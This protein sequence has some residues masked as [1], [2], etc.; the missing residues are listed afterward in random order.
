MRI[1]FA[2]LSLCLSHLVYADVSSIEITS[3]ETLSAS[4]QAFSYQKVEG[5]IHLTLDP[6][7]SGNAAIVDIEF[8]PTNFEGLVEYAVDFKM[9]IPSNNIA[10]G[11][12]LYGVN[13]RGRLQTPPENELSA[14]D[15]SAVISELT[16]GGYTYLIT[17]WI[18]ELQS[19]AGRIRLHAPTVSAEQPITGDVRYELSVGGEAYE[20]EIA[21]AGHLA[22]Q[23][24]EAGMRNASLT[25]RLYQT[26][27][28]VPIERSRYDLIVQQ[29]SGANQP[30]VIIR[31]EDGFEPG[32]LYELIYEAQDPVLAG[33]GM[34][35]IRDIVSAIRYDEGEQLAELDLPEIDHTIAYGFSQS[36]RLLRQFVYDGFNA[37]LDQRKVFDGVVPYIAGGGYGMF[38][39]RFAMPTRTNGHHSNYLYPNDLFPFTYGESTDPYTGRTDSLLAKARATNTVPKVMH[40]QTTNEYWLR[41]GSLPHTT[42]EGREDSVIPEEVRFYTIGGS[43]H[44]SGSGMIPGEPTGGQLPRNPNMWQPIGLSLIIAMHDWI[45]ND[46][47]PPESVYPKIADGTLVAS[48]GRGGINNKAWNPLRGYNYPGSMYQPAHANY[49][50]RWESDRIVDAHP[51]YSDHFYRALVPAVDGNN[52]DLANSTILPPLTDVPLATFVSWNMRNPT[53]GAENSLA[54]LAGGYIPLPKDATRAAENGDQRD[55]IAGLYP[56]FSD[57]LAKYEASVD[58]LVERRFLLPEMKAIY[59]EIAHTRA[60]IFE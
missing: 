9:L 39:L 1:V 26:D 20:I 25:R 5:L 15:G 49:G 53:T 3:R 13:N 10:N 29:D 14:P 36:G 22:Y 42:P 56:S 28:R 54:R 38:N 4:G 33:A 37:D 16:S 48:H 52:N 59:M 12:L 23:P 31:M 35:A 7:D 51:D 17:G 41:A 47:A 32:V 57:Y 18:N 43:Q 21:G 6:N 2:V 58:S 45:A 19:G 60:S 34:A 40:I 55:S 46:V 11:G 30:R 27:P 24:T 50:S 44:G 8:A